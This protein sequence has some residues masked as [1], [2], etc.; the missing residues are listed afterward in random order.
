MG[1]SFSLVPPLTMLPC[2]SSL[3]FMEQG[4][5]LVRAGLR[6]PVIRQGRWAWRT[7]KEAGERFANSA[8][9]Q[10]GPTTLTWAT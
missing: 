7:K 8:Q 5:Q 6:I 10:D 1:G 9:C 4:F 3:F 2:S